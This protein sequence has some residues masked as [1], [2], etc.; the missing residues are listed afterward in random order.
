MYDRSNFI[1]DLKEKKRH[2]MLIHSTGLESQSLM[3]C[4]SMF[5]IQRLTYIVKAH[6]LERNE[7]EFRHN[8]TSNKNIYKNV[9]YMHLEQPVNIGAFRGFSC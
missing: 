7:N 4:Y 2:P 5:N 8:L 3:L 6:I 9:K 1:D